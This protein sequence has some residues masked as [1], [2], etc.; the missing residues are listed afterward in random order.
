MQPLIK[1]TRKIRKHLVRLFSKKLVKRHND[2]WFLLD[3]LNWI[4]NRIV[5]G[6]GYEEPL[7]ATMLSA[8]R[9]HKIDVMLDIGANIGYY[10]LL[11]A[12]HCD[13]QQIHAFEPVRRNLYQFH[14]NQYLNGYEHKIITY[15]CGLSD[16]AGTFTIHIDP[17][18]TGISRLSLDHAQRNIKV[19]TEQ[20]VVRVEVLD[21]FLQMSGRQ[22]FVKID[23]E[24]HE[25]NVLNGMQMFLK[26][27]KCFMQVEISPENEKAVSN[28]LQGS[29]YNYLKSIGDN[30]YYSNF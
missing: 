2:V 1:I 5:A 18:S 19:F 6:Y 26:D 4:D 11:V 13:V 30:A 14:A 3:P 21:S 17:R 29:G 15:N 9:E 27:N 10:S 23:T 12:K 8:I 25:L 28:L 20:E 22:V 7:V 16:A 24:G